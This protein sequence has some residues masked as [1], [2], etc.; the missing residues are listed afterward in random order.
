MIL[1]FAILFSFNFAIAV[2]GFRTDLSVLP[3]PVQKWTER[4]YAV[5]VPINNHYNFIGTAFHFQNDSQS[6]YFISAQHVLQIC[7]YKCVLIKNVEFVGS[8]INVENIKTNGVPIILP[9]VVEIGMFDPDK[10][11]WKPGSFSNDIGYLK[12]TL[13]NNDPEM[14]TFLD[15]KINFSEISNLKVDM[16]HYVLGYPVLFVRINN[17]HIEAP[18]IVKLRYSTG[19]KL[20]SRHEIYSGGMGFKSQFGS[21]FIIDSDSDTIGGNSGG[22]VVS[23][24]GQLIGVLFGGPSNSEYYPEIIYNSYIVPANYIKYMIHEY[25]KKNSHE[26]EKIVPSDIQPTVLNLNSP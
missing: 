17:E 13:I 16:R 3:Q 6:S 8:N 11:G 15:L 4:V 18:N 5:A 1:F 14:L 19:D 9:P 12:T 7:R 26:L 25:L 2:E 20:R 21:K 22:P 23:E 10:K 24:D